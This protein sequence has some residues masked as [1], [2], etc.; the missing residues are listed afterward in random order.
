[1]KGA[2]E[3]ANLFVTGQYG[4]MYI[5]SGNHGRGRTFRIFILPEGEQAKENGPNNACLNESAV[6]VYGVVSGQPGWT[7][8]YSW[9]HYGKWVEDFHAMASFATEVARDKAAQQTDRNNLA[10]QKQVERD[11][12]L[13]ATY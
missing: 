6:E 5:V 7:E 8:E 9:I 13:L 12:Q 10:K 2:R 3:Y 11:L 1:M 4:R